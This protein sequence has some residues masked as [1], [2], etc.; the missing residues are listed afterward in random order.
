MATLMLENGSDI[1]FIEAMFGHT[2]LST[3]Q[4]YTQLSVRQL[5]AIRTA[6]HPGTD[7]QA[8]RTEGRNCR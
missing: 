2:E 4:I 6:M 1:R 7:R 8:G 5:K 3:T